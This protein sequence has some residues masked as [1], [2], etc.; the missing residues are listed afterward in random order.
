MR[1]I[2]SWAIMNE[3]RAF[4]VSRY[5]DIEWISPLPEKRFCE[6][7]DDLLMALRL[8]EYHYKLR[9]FWP[10]NMPS[11]DGLAV[12]RLQNQVLFLIE[13]KSYPEETYTE[14]KAVNRKS[15]ARIQESLRTVQQYMG[16]D[17]KHNWLKPF[18]QVC[19]RLAFLYFFTVICDHPAYLVF[20]NFVEDTTISNPVTQQMWKAHYTDIYRRIGITAESPLMD[21][22]IHLYPSAR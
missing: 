12:M 17:P 15:L 6:H 8:P 21:R 5:T 11:W 4:P 3:C 18:Y 20:I 1:P 10:R 19:N 9:A 2:L 22:V 14:T 7:R 16:V 13:A